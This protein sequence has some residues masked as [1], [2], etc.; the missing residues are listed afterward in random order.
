M[1]GRYFFDED[2]NGVDDDEPGIEGAIVTLLDAAGQPT[3]RT[4]TTDANGN[5]SFIGLLAG[6]YAVAFAAEAS[7]MTFVPQDQGDD[8][9]IDSDVNGN[10]VSGPITVAIGETS[11]DND[12]GVE[13]PGTAS[14]GDTVFFDENRNGQQDAG[15]EGIAGVQVTL[16]DVNGGPDVVTTTDSDGN[17]L[18]AG[19]DAGDYQV[20][21]EAV[22]EFEFTQTDAGNDASDS[23]ADEETGT[24][25]VISLEIGEEDLTIDAGLVIANEEPMLTD[26]EAIGCA[27]DEIT[28][29]VLANDTDLDGEALSVTAVNGVA[30]TE[31]GT[32]TIDGVEI[33]LNGGALTFD[34]EAAFEG[35]DIGEQETVTYEYTVTD[36]IE[37]STA[38]AAITFKGDANSVES[39]YQSLPDDIEVTF[40]GFRAQSAY[41]ATFGETGDNRLDGLTIDVAYCIERTEQFVSG[42]T[43]SGSLSG[44]IEGEV[45]AGDFESNAADV[46][47]NITW[48]VNQ[49][50][51][52]QDSGDGTNYTDAEIQFAIWGL[53]DSDSSLINGADASAENVAELLEMAQTLGEGFEAGENDLVGLIIDPDDTQGSLS[54]DDDHDQ[55]FIVFVPFEDLDCIC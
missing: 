27:E 9:T 36:G 17:Y 6:T 34:G 4:T 2:G 15:E 46:L 8:D 51:T 41:T 16:T 13:D 14:L 1:A 26:D 32:I 5:Y 28:V 43:I 21:F 54:E 11:T 42:Q 30:I 50:F 52:S 44:A 23:D 35:L 33:T 25:D 45:S 19:L 39:L 55:G 47:D 40:T 7:G 12:A 49:D 22:D 24:T 3:G 29:D 10:G 48:L 20:T 38:D 53:T 31:G 37:T 18:F